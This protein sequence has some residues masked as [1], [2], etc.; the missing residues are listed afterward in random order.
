MLNAI[1]VVILG[2]VAFWMLAAIFEA[3]GFTRH[4]YVARCSPSLGHALARDT[5]IGGRR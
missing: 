5:N 1:L 3:I 2:L 4:R